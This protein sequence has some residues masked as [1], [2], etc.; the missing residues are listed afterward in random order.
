M[1]IFFGWCVCFLCLG[2]AGRDACVCVFLIDLGYIILISFAHLDQVFRL[3][4]FKQ[5]FLCKGIFILNKNKPLLLPPI[6][7]TLFLVS[8]DCFNFITL[9]WCLLFFL[10]HFYGDSTVWWVCNFSIISRRRYACYNA[11][12]IVNNSSGKQSM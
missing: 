8:S 7:P 3:F 2:G 6:L 11:Y 5:C 9:N 12:K 10:S 1:F 4:L